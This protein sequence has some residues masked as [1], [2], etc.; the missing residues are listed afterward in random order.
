MIIITTENLPKSEISRLKY[1]GHGPCIFRDSSSDEL[2]QL[3]AINRS[4]DSTLDKNLNRVYRQMYACTDTRTLIKIVQ[5]SISDANYWITS[6]DTK[7]YNFDLLHF[8]IQWTAYVTYACQQD[9][10]WTIPIC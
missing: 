5:S 3:A 4:W 8:I 6:M 2:Y 7:A 9:L 1:T 10:V